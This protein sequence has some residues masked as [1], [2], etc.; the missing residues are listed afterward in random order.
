MRVPAVGGAALLVA[1]VLLTACG[2][3][4]GGRSP[5]PS[6]GP[7]AWQ[8]LPEP[9][10]AARSGPVVAWTGRDV[11]VVG[12]DVGPP[13]PRNADCS[14]PARYARDGARLD[15]AR[16][17]WHPMSAAPVDV[18]AYAPHALVSGRL[19]VLAG[20][21]LLAY[22]VAHDTWS[23][24]QTPASVADQQLVAAGDRLVVAS[25]TDEHGVTPDRVYEPA[26]GHWST[27]PD[28]PVGPAF[29]RVL[30][31]IPTGL[32]LTAHA[33]VENPGAEEPSLV[34]AA[35]WDSA[36]GVWTR[37]PDSDQ[38]GGWAWTWTGRRLVDP[39][40]GGA[41]GGKVG[42][43]GRTIPMGGVLDPATGAWSRLRHAPKEGTGGWPVS[44]LG[45]RFAAVGGWTYDDDT[46]SWAPVPR[47]HGAPEQ[48]GAAVW[49]GDRLVVVGGLEGSRGDASG[50][51]AKGAWVSGPGDTLGR[52]RQ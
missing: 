27:L 46:E 45:G 8:R 9:P 22:D 43:Y 15:L 10:W 13:C 50:S 40:L 19:Y 11:L 32:V 16:R 39:S 33:L 52:P 28:D 38:L 29:D 20:A 42:N 4:V 36:A 44:A 7:A 31:A 14:Q 34:L 49:A 21:A 26:S 25:G 48:P 1:A 24:I 18:P 3:A 30:V 2:V 41:D 6:A 35:R 51:R 12:G 37:L 23:Q 5:D 47:P 17:A